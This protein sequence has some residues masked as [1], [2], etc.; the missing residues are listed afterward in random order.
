MKCMMHQPSPPSGIYFAEPFFLN[1]KNAQMQTSMELKKVN[2]SCETVK[3]MS[4]DKITAE[5]PF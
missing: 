4:T 1:I 2:K 3:K 5:H